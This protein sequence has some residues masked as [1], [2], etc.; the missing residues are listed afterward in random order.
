[1]LEQQLITSIL[2]TGM[3][4]RG[5]DWAWG[6]AFETSKPTPSDT[7][8]PTRPHFLPNLCQSLRNRN[9]TLKYVSLQSHS[10]L[11]YHCRYLKNNIE[12][13]IEVIQVEV[14]VSPKLFV[15]ETRLSTECLSCHGISF[16][17][18][19]W[20]V[21]ASNLCMFSLLWVGESMCLWPLAFQRTYCSF[22][23][24]QLYTVHCLLNN[25]ILVIQ[26][27]INI[28]LD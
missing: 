8:S 17:G 20:P 4:Q 3:R 21:S 28:L 12:K 2:S 6:G 5:L 15:P 10:H 23:I 25:F 9:Q 14:S 22:G 16:S 18:S 13:S 27:I 24:Q 1:M 7:P 11:N 26:N 19:C